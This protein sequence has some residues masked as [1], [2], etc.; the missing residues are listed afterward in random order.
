M[1]QMCFRAC[2][3]LWV[4]YTVGQCVF[5]LFLMAIEAVQ[6]SAP[7]SS[8]FVRTE[9]SGEMCIR[10]MSALSKFLITITDGRDALPRGGLDDQAPRGGLDPAGEAVPLQGPQDLLR[11]GL[12]PEHDRAG[13]EEAGQGLRSRD[14]VEG[15]CPSQAACC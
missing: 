13:P 6:N 11:A 15:G 1:F 5:S 4:D 12:L 7:K 9:T 10:D 3:S 14:L 8:E 2:A